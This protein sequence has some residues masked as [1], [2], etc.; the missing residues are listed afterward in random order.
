MQKNERVK[1]VRFKDH[2]KVSPKIIAAP[3]VKEL[4][5]IK[6]APKTLRATSIE[7]L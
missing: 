4:P 5:K 6:E 1:L 3:K 2:S 7:E